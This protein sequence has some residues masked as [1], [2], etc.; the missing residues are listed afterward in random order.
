MYVG[1]SKREKAGE[2]TKSFLCG[3][4]LVCQ[5]RLWN[6]FFYQLYMLL[7]STLRPLYLDLFSL[8]F[9]LFCG[10][11]FVLDL[12]RCKGWVIMPNVLCASVLII[13]VSLSVFTSLM[14]RVMWFSV[15]AV[16]Y[17]CTHLNIHSSGC[18]CRFCFSGLK[19][20]LWL[21]SDPEGFSLCVIVLN[22][23]PDTNL[24]SIHIF[25][26]SFFSDPF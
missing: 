18:V 13:I 24:F 8:S 10:S 22:S 9:W 20:R 17:A 4:W 12:G 21:T 3:Y 25:H 16:F 1:K 6:L 19:S 15:W 11:V 7:G 14:C 26:V 23:G 5:C 2:L